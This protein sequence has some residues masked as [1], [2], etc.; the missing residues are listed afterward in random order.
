MRWIL[1]LAFLALAACEG[2]VVEPSERPAPTRPTPEDQG[3]E[4]VAGPRPA[5]AVAQSNFRSVVSRVEPVAERVCRDRTRGVNCN[6][7]IVVDTRRGIPPNAF[8]TLDRDGRPILGFTAALIRDARNQDE[9]AFIMGHEAAHHIR[10]HIPRAQQSAAGA[11]IIAGALASAGGAEAA[12]IR[13]A[14]RVGAAVGARRFS[15]SFE[16]EA[17]ELGTIIAARAGYDPI[18]GAEYFARV[19]DPGNQF[20][21]SHPPNADRVATVRRVAAGL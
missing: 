20:L 6:F 17:D 10:G 15:K 16:L 3:A 13:D 18:R 19:P 12:V 11:A 9:L 1:A 14:Q 2:V 8:Q 4:I 5:P 21:G 7:Q